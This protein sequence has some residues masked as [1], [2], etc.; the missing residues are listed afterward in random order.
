ML[1]FSQRM[2]FTPI[3]DGLQK[4][5]MDGA[6]R[7][8]LWNLLAE[9][10]WGNAEVLW[11]L[12][13]NKS[14]P[15]LL[16]TRYFNLLLEDIPNTWEAFRLEQ[17][18]YF[19]GCESKHV[20]DFIEFLLNAN[21]PEY[22]S[23]KADFV[24]RCNEVLER[25]RSAY[26]IVNSHFVEITSEAEIAAIEGAI[27]TTA[28]SNPLNL[29]GIHLQRAV[30]SLADRAAPDLPNSMKESISAVE[31]LCKLITGDDKATLGKALNA[32]ENKRLVPMHPQIKQAFHS[33][34]NYTSDAGGIRHALK[35][36]PDVALEDATFMLV[37]CSAFVNYM[38]EKARKAGTAL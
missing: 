11:N 25:E 32:I 16:W 7:N 12:L 31:A 20:Y 33:L 10:Y 21:I 27:A 24:P 4:D 6:L 5:S 13:R 2:G 23:I 3:R 30:T 36:A 9:S 18:R 37:T 15:S 14:L 22:E 35:D 17:R 34:Y 28:A 19:T 38:V 1:P 26:R 29:V 8:G